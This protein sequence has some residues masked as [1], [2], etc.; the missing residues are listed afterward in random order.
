MTM[1][2]HRL[3]QCARRLAANLSRRDVA[4]LAGLGLAA[5]LIAPS[6]L[7]ARKKKKKPKK[8]KRG[9]Q[10]CG[11]TCI[12]ASACCG[13]CAPGQ[14]CYR[15]R[16]GAGA[17]DCPAGANVCGAPAYNTA[18]A[19]DPTCF[20]FQTVEGETRCGSSVTGCGTCTS[21]AQCAAMEPGLACGIAP[22]AACQC[23]PGQGFCIKPCGA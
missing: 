19:G 10:K 6:D 4:G 17:G 18:C 21:S 20:C 12:A 13:G 14:I 23:A 16:C 15:G 9:L 5:W 8:C 22:V 2:H 1:E 11:K 7:A 3:D